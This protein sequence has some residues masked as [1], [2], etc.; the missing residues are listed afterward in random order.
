MRTRKGTT[1]SRGRK[2]E[3]D[4]FYTKSAVAAA[5]IDAVAIND[6]DV[7]IEPSAGSGSFSH[8]LTG[9]GANVIAID[10]NPPEDA[11][12]IVAMDWFDYERKRGDGNVLVIGNPPFGQQ[13]NLAVAFINHAAEF[14]SVVAF[15]LP[16]SFA[17]E[18]VQRRIDPH[19]HLV[20]SVPL[21]PSSF[22]REGE[23]V[24]IPCTFQTWE[25]REEVREIPPIPQSPTKFFFVKKDDEDNPPDAY[26]QRVGGRA[27]SAGTKWKDRSPQSNLFIHCVD[28]ADVDDIV[29][30]VNAF[31]FGSECADG[32]V[33]PKSIG[34]REMLR[35]LQEKAPA[36]FS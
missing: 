1:K 25:W 10:I 36:L 7:V 9:K 6:F 27:G 16:R 2:D 24:D 29:A 22:T 32:V 26:I 15:I 5:C 13:N 21:P 17:K 33:G 20:R 35:I 3:L 12:D 30:I 4:R 18:S 31:V 19:L 34:K 28:T 23:D 11:A 8:I 14:A